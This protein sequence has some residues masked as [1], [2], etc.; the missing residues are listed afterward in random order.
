M[1]E[2]LIK[3]GIV[4][5]AT[6]V[7]MTGCAKKPDF[8]ISSVDSAGQEFTDWEYDGGK[9]ET[10]AEKSEL[11]T[12]HA[13]PAGVVQ[14]VDDAVTL[15]GVGE[16][17]VVRDRSDLTEITN[18]NGDEAFDARDGTIYFQ[19]LGKDISYEGKSSADLPVNITVRYYLDD[20]EMKPDEIAGKKGHVKVR[21]SFDNSE[22]CRVESGEGPREVYVP[23]AAVTVVTLEPD[24]YTNLV[25]HDCSESSFNSENVIMAV[26]MPG[27]KSDLD[28]LSIDSSDF[29]IPESFSFEMDTDSFEMGFSTTVVTS[30]LLD[31]ENR[32]GFDDFDEIKDALSDLGSAGKKIADG[33]TKIV[34]GMDSFEGYLSGYIEGVGGLDSGISGLKDGFDAL[35]E[36]KSGIYEGAKGISDGLSAYS[37]AYDEIK[38]LI[39]G[40]A[41]EDPDNEKIKALKKWYDALSDQNALLSE[42]STK[43]TD[44]VKIFNK[45]ISSLRRGVRKLKKGSST[46]SSQGKKLSEGYSSLSTGF[47]KYS[48][49]VEKFYSEGIA[50]LRQ[51]GTDTINDI[52]RLIRTM[53]NAG[54]IYTTYSGLEEGQKGHVSIIIEIEA[55][56][57]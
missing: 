16:S 11:V 54:K 14:S 48:E 31:G 53:E 6:C 13:D 27:V 21:Y 39:D 29:D 52:E 45:S 15:K 28:I 12:A 30:N 49:A 34:D 42:T 2:K 9:Y 56:E 47:V 25:T 7:L 40:M 4:L 22:L 18:K 5:L 20:E 1:R 33:S 36:N 24:S 35:D 10:A 44:G 55:V 41:E 17:D 19:N 46:L 57:P 23:F 37:K 38:P 43:Y 3:L 50:K 26:T 51:K 8:D 32:F